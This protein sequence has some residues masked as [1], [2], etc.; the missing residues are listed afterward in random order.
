MRAAMTWRIRLASDRD[1]RAIADI[2]APFVESSA[3]SFETEAPSADEIRRRVQE[4]TITHPWLVCACGDAV[5]GYA[6]ATKHRARTAYQWSVEVS[7]YVHGSFRRAGVGRGLYT[8]LFAILAAQGFVHA[9]A[10]ITLPNESSVALHESLGFRPVGV[11]RTIGYKAG[12]WHDVGWWHLTVKEP[13]ASPQP[14]VLLAD[15]QRQPGWDAMLSA[16]M[17]LIRAQGAR[18]HGSI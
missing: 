16:G 8:S 4:T 15:I 11:Y 17:P 10:G 14:P 6:Y 13:P 3:T 2:Y 7:V 12:A 5:A 18:G 9:Y 1:A